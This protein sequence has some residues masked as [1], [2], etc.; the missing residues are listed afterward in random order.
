MSAGSAL[1]FCLHAVALVG[2]SRA[3]T[4]GRA[5]LAG[6][7]QVMRTR[8]GA[9]TTGGAPEVAQATDKVVLSNADL[10]KLF[11]RIADK[12]VLMDE[13]AGA[14]CHSGCDGCPYRYS[15][16]VLEAVAPKWVV[17]YTHKTI[18]EREHTPLWLTTAFP[19]KKKVTRAEFA[20]RVAAAP[21]VSPIGPALPAAERIALKNDPELNVEVA[22]AFFTALAGPGVEGL[23]PVGAAKRLREMSAGKD[24]LMFDP[25]CVAVRAALS[26]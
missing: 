12:V 5:G 22:A 9:A 25:F 6:G 23:S 11:G 19:D 16:D 4:G 24:G 14:C 13:S 3:L 20:E 1:V 21:F 18:G 7:G 15:F 17:T 8:L 2:G 10:C 26:V